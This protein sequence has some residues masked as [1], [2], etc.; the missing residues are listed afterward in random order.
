MI[1]KW[2]ERT[3]NSTSSFGFKKNKVLVYKKKNP[4]EWLAGQYELPTFI[5]SSSDKN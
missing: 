2:K 1:L 4:K 3:W 5:I